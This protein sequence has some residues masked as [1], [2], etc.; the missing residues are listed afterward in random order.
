MHEAAHEPA[1]PNRWYGVLRSAALGRRPVAVRRLGLPIVL[2]RRADGSPVA[3]LDRCSHRGA[4][5]SRGRVRG[6]EIECPYHAFRFDGGG[7]CTAI[8]CEGP[9]ARIPGGMDVPAFAVR[10]AHGVVWLWWGAA[11]QALGLAELP[12]LPWLDAI[13]EGPDVARSEMDYVWPVPLHRTLEANFDVYHAAVIH[14]F[15]VPKLGRMT[16]CEV[17]ACVVEGERIQ[18][19][20]DTFDP[21]D[22]SAHFPVVVT[23]HLPGVTL[24]ELGDLYKIVTIDAPIDD[25]HVWRCLIHVRPNV[26]WAHLGSLAMRG[27]QRL[28]YWVT[29]RL[30][31]LPPVRSQTL[32]V[33]GVFADKLVRADAGTAQY[34]RLR[35]KLLREEAA[36]R[37]LLPAHVRWASGWTDEPGHVPLAALGRPR[38]AA[39][40]P[41]S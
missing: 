29:Q 9:D 28:D 12:P 34:I 22:R 37:H 3:L 27:W 31:D 26:R 17:E 40:A 36:R 16:Q 38:A 14:S 7:R 1:I 41:S 23:S 18:L 32:P 11:P 39:D 15:G 2:Y 25:D 13:P 8:P 35:R 24:I 6:D 21:H 10:E 5:L 4:A 30:Q 20:V 19:R 33:P